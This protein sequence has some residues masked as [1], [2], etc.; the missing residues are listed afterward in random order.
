MN[1]KQFDSKK[2]K[3]LAEKNKSLAEKV[4]TVKIP[5]LCQ[6][7]HHCSA[8]DAGVLLSQVP[9]YRLLALH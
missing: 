3:S 6:L 1:A 5:D 8:I 2:N 7:K 9:K 4:H